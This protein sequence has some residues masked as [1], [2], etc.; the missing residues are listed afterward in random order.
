MYQSVKNDLLFLS[1]PE[2]AISKAKY[3]KSG[4]GEYA[5][6]DVF[7]GLTN[8]EVHQICKHY[9]DLVNLEDIEMLIKDEIHEVRF[10]ALTLLVLKYKK[11]KKLEEKT[12]FV[13]L[14]LRNIPYINNWDL[15]DCSSMFIL[16]PYCYETKDNS[17]LENLAN[18]GHLWS[19][20]IAI[21]ST[22]YYIR[23]GDF[24]LT[25][26]L[27]EMLLNHKH[28][29]IHKAVG[30]MLREIWSKGGRE[31]VEEFLTENF[32]VIPRTALRYAIEKMEEHERKY[33]LS[34]K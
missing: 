26:K 25:F 14:Y 22:H 30:W 33:F 7:I 3:F 27:S 17:V 13:N 31:E 20:R 32:R 15:V 2:K 1:N 21:I 34:L 4:K 28:D 16:G 12:D 6:G 9:R 29:L 19:E 8:P 11:L 10:A 5:E 23:Q 24:A 18:I